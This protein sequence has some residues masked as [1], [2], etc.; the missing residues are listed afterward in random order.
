MTKNQTPD[1]TFLS[2]K[3]GTIFANHQV[4]R[5]GRPPAGSDL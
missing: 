5:T 1:F 2:V 3:S 4:D